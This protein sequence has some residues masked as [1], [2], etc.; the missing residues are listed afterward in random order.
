MT[1]PTR[2]CFRAPPKRSHTNGVLWL[3]IFKI[4]LLYLSDVRLGLTSTQQFSHSLLQSGSSNILK[5]S[6]ICRYLSS[7]LRASITQIHQNFSSIQFYSLSFYSFVIFC[8]QVFQF[9][10]ILP[11]QTQNNN[12]IENNIGAVWVSLKEVISYLN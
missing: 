9:H 3:L 8:T 12:L 6:L 4:N 10:F 1:N 5:I 11:N 2:I 7:N